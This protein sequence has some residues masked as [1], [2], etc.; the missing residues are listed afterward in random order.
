MLDNIESQ[1]RPR[2]AQPAAGDNEV[3]AQVEKWM[4]VIRE[5]IREET[6]R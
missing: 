4:E 3:F 6:K 5:I 1:R 2:S